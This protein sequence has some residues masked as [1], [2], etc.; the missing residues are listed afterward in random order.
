MKTLN[1]PLVWLGRSGSIMFPRSA[2]RSP[3]HPHYGFEEGVIEGIYTLLGAQR[4]YP[5]ARQRSLRGLGPSR[6]VPA[7]LG[8]GFLGDTLLE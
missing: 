6:L 3:Y 5:E 2:D 7:V 8:S 1:C 4:H